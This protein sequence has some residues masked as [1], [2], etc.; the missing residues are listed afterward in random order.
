M[1]QAQA[2][3]E[4]IYRAPL[5]GP[6]RVMHLSGDQERVITQAG[7]RQLLPGQVELLAGPG[8]PSSICPAA[9]VYQAIRLAGQHGVT[10]LVDEN[11][12]R[13]PGPD[14]L[15]GP[16]NLAEAQAQGGDVRVVR[17]PI[18]AVV[19][20]RADRLRE[21]VLFVAG[22]ETLLA[23]LAGMILEGLP[24]NLSLLVCGRHVDVLIEQARGIGLP[25]YDALLLPGNRYS[26]LGLAAWRRFARKT[27]KPVA[28]AGYTGQAVLGAVR[29][30]VEQVAAGQADL[31][32]CYR[33]MAREAGNPL[34]RQR[35]QQVFEV[36][37]GRW[38]G[39]GA[40]GDS[41]YRLREAYGRHDADRRYPD[42]RPE[43]RGH[44]EFAVGCD[45]TSVLIGRSRP[46]DCPA[47]HRGCDPELPLGPCMASGDGTCRIHSLAGIG[48]F[49]SVV[50]G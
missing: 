39:V 30:L 36:V 2:I 41:A 6:M 4:A 43:V 48:D 24:D 13:T 9:D 1:Q 11:L 27:G 20:A 22:F 49:G 12:W 35:L 34:A 40:V 14:G 26:L 45:C 16:R 38:R 21:M 47:Y 10:L 3:L 31:I 28:V 19:A 33:P 42:F 46:V 44:D 17:A 32:N 50:P 29:D 37:P 15:S 7:L 25:A 8:C 23:P 18:E 5:G